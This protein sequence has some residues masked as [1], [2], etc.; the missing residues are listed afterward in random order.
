MDRVEANELEHAGF[1]SRLAAFVLDLLTL[2]I[3]SSAAVW[4]VKATETLLVPFA[5]FGV[6]DALYRALAAAFPLFWLAYFAGLWWLTGQPLGPEEA[7][8]MAR[9]RFATMESEM[10][11]LWSDVTGRGDVSRAR[12]E[13]TAW[14]RAHPIRHS[15]VRPSTAPLLA[16][17]TATSGVSPMGAAAALIETS[18]DLSARMDVL[19]TTLFKQVR[20]Q[21][22]YFTRELVRDP[23]LLGR[24][25]A[26][27]TGI[28]ASLAEL[29]GVAHAGRTPEGAVE[30]EPLE[31]VDQ[32]LRTPQRSLAETL[33][34]ER[35]VLESSRDS[36]IRS[37]SRRSSAPTRWCG[38]G[39]IARSS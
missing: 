15:G 34:Q 37:G 16:E 24:Q 29:L 3:G 35:R 26:L 11:A 39:S 14:A 1:V 17:V 27:L 13:V 33:E 20:W 23:P 38:A 8:A 7:L 36:S 30:A 19:S 5:T 4:V 6:R 9:E 31:G 25:T 10:S 28:S 2:A 18:Q 21:A 12:A 32:A 22:E